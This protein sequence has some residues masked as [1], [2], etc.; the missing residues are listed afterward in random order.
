MVIALASAL[1]VGQKPTTQES[2]KDR[3]YIAAKF[4]TSSG[5]VTVYLPN[6]I[7][8]GDQISGTIFTDSNSDALKNLQVFIGDVLGSQPNLRSAQRR[9]LVPTTARDGYPLIVRDKSGR[10]IGAMRIPI[11]AAPG[12]LDAYTFP[13]FMQVGRPS[14]IWGPF[15]GDSSNTKLKLKDSDMSVLAESPRSIV[16][17]V[18]YDSPIGKSSAVLVENQMQAKA[19]IRA[20]SI[21]LTSGKSELKK[22]ESTTVSIKVD[23]IAGLNEATVPYIRVQNLTP[24][25]LDLEGQE[26]HVLIPTVSSSGT[27]QKDF[28]ALSKE[29]GPFLITTFVEPGQGTPVLPSKISAN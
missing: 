9:W 25:I 1:L 20:I 17:Y 4:A 11:S 13:S 26:I 15:D 2:L 14:V 21:E 6:D 5:G 16:V 3:G 8:P 22:N 10:Q 23:G 24:N 28:K 12:K 19:D 29:A 18:P 7:A 27:Y